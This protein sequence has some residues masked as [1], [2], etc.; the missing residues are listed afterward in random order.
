M[1][2]TKMKPSGYFSSSIFSLITHHA[3]P[4]HEQ[5]SKAKQKLRRSDSKGILAYSCTILMSQVVSCASSVT[6]SSA[7]SL[8]CR[9]AIHTSSRGEQTNAGKHREVNSRGDEPRPWRAGARGSHRL[10]HPRPQCSCCSIKHH[11]T[12]N[13]VSQRAAISAIG[14]QKSFAELGSHSALVTST[15][16]STKPSCL[17]STL[18]NSCRNVNVCTLTANKL[19][20]KVGQMGCVTTSTYG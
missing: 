11:I 4:K 9:E 2:P 10:D 3:R 1:R 8:I 15:L 20:R 19:N 7:Q 13:Q 12:P 16:G 17:R 18:A 6:D 5:A 14:K